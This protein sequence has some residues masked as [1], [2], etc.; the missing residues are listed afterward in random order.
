MRT[1]KYQVEEL[2]C[3]SCIKKIEGALSKQEGVKEAKVLFNSNKVKVI[4]DEGIVSSDQL[5]N[6]VQ[7]LGYP[8]LGSKIA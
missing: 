2:T 8:V 7:K 4:F 3:P 6:I 5:R 1:V